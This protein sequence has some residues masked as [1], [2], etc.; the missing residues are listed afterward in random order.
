MEDPCVVLTTPRTTSISRVM[1]ASIIPEVEVTKMSMHK[2]IL[3][4]AIHHKDAVVVFELEGTQL[5]DQGIRGAPLEAVSGITL[6]LHEK[7][8]QN[9]GLPQ[10][11]NTGEAR[12]KCWFY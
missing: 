9:T 11:P 10:P 8:L 3:T 6:L 7:S 2:L 12:M 5:V 4:S 1:A